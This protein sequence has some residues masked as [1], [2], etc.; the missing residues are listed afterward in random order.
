MH[1]SVGLLG[2]TQT[3]GVSGVWCGVL[4]LDLMSRHDPVPRNTAAAGGW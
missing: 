2:D 1:A 3:V 4:Y